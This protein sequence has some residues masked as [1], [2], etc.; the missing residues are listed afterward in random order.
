MGMFTEVLFPGTGR[1]VQ[2]N[3][4]RDDCVRYEIG[5]EL[6][7]ELAPKDTQAYVFDGLDIIDGHCKNYFVVVIDRK[8][9]AVIPSIGEDLWLE[10]QFIRLCYN[11]D[12]PFTSTWEEL[13][14]YVQQPHWYNKLWEWAWPWSKKNKQ[15]RACKNID[16]EEVGKNLC[17]PIKQQIGYEGLARRIFKVTLIEEKNDKSTL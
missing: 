1:L 17:N 9:V 6:K 12:P 7:Y 3:T 13:I 16:W 5:Q 15:R 2:F 8:I 11:A 4:G 14:D 10:R